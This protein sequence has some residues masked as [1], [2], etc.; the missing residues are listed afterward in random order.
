MESTLTTG[1]RRLLHVCEQT[2]EQGLY[3]FYEVGKALL[4]IRKCKLYR[5]THPT[6][7]LYCKDRWQFTARYAR[8]QISAWKTYQALEDGAAK[9]LNERQCRP[10]QGLPLD[11]RAQAWEKAV[12]AAGSAEK[13]YSRHVA[14]AVDSLRLKPSRRRTFKITLRLCE[15]CGYSF[16]D[17]HHLKPQSS[18]GRQFDRI[19]L[20]PNHHRYATILQQQMMDSLPRQQIE[21]YAAKHFDR[22]FNKRLLPHILGRTYEI[23]NDIGES[24]DLFTHP[25]V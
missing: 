24:L 16:S 1:E 9:P 2:I 25:A 5:Q 22:F 12:L 21:A 18:G 17:E 19:A 20:C 8:N 15:V 3:T 13:T 10:L 6:F 23:S 4:T 7:E 14:A 11:K